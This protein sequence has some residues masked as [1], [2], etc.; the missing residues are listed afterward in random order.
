MELKQVNILKWYR[1][2][3]FIHNHVDGKKTNVFC[4]L[5]V[6]F[7]WLFPSI[8]VQYI[9]QILPTMA[10]IIVILLRHTSYKNSLGKF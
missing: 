2:N 4:L 7:I 3:K 6:A 8:F 9:L 10:L 1:E 5:C